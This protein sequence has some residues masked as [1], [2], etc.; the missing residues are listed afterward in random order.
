MEIYTS[1]F[2]NIKRL[3]T[4]G[5]M[6][7]GIA[8]WKPRF[9]EGV[10]MYSVAPTRYMLSDDCEHEEYLELYDEILRKRGAASIINEINSIAHGRNVALLCY[11]KPGDFCHR[12]LLA[13][14]LNKE[15]GLN[16]REYEAP[17][18]A[19]KPTQTS[20]FD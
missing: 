6:P 12:H 2:G 14:F 7:I 17:A 5:I 15:L 10:C 9:Y 13:D 1:Y 20:L 16:I 4:A 11:E 8:R 3:G 19:P 18:P